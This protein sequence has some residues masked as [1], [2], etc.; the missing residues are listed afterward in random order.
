MTQLSEKE[1]FKTEEWLRNKNIHSV[2]TRCQSCG[3]WGINSPCNHICGNCGSSE[4]I[5]Y[6]DIETVT[7]ERKNFSNIHESLVAEMT[8]KSFILQRM[9]DLLKEYNES[10]IY[11]TYEGGPKHTI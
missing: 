8:V 6:Y 11:P 1:L 10:K 4:T 3:G 5:L 9:A 2:Y 7:N